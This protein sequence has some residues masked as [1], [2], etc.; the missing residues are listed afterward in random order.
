MIWFTWRQFRAQTVV[1]GAAL[2]A[3]AVALIV[4]G[5]HLVDLYTSSGLAACHASCGTEATNFINQVKGSAAEIVFYVG[6]FLLYA[7][8]A[9]IG[10]FWGAPLVTRELEAGTFRLAWNQSIT[11][12]RWIA[13]K[14][15]LIGLAAMATTGL[16]SLM[17]S[18]WAAP[19][20]RA[21]QKAGPNSL[22]INKFE[23]ALFGATGVAPIGYAAFA[24]ALGVTIGVLV[25]RTLSAMALTLAL[26]AAIQ[27]LWPGYVRPHLM[28][29]VTTVQPLGTVSFNGFGDTDNGHLLMD[30]G[31]VSGKT[32]DWIT[33]S[34][35]VNSAG[36]A[37]SIAPRG[38]MISSGNFLQCLSNNGVR[39]SVSYQP[40]SRY[41]AFQW[42]DAGIFLVLALGLGGVCYWRIRRVA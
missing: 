41:W 19:L 26:F 15:A 27:I 13:V 32:G 31:S 7:A 14:L 21:A 4:T 18:W 12:T 17:T 6:I 5:P 23:P 20:Y 16:L 42:Y 8:P 28:T 35:T 1:A 33:A 38:C 30:V 9:I 10:M 29:P 24:F 22:S 34:H 40:T 3:M 11:R 25:R 36:Q 39:M 37:I 2:A